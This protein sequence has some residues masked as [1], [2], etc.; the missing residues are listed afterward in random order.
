VRA[1]AIAPSS[2][3]AVA[4]R[5]ASVARRGGVRVSYAV[6]ETG[7]A[8]FTVERVRHRANAAGVRRIRL[9]GAFR[10]GALRGRNTLRFT[11]HLRGRAL[12]PGRYN[13]VL[14]VTDLT[15]DSSRV[16]RARFRIIR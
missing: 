10:Q 9:R 12:A 1:L 8:R 7:T 13:L 14:R 3:H 2:F 16:Q 4:G 5:H 11:G 15:G 6:S